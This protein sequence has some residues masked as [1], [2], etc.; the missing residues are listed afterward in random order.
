MYE[1]LLIHFSVPCTI[2]YINL[3]FLCSIYFASFGNGSKD[4]EENLHIVNFARHKNATFLKF[5][6]ER[7]QVLF[8]M[9]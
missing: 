1:Y 5:S 3:K 4:L 8:V 2:Q 9:L 6:E 7:R